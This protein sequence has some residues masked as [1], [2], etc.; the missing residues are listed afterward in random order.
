MV[1][2]LYSSSAE[3]WIV[4]YSADSDV[5]AGFSEE[6]AISDEE[7]QRHLLLLREFR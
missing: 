5:P 6:I 1:D 4:D 7:V 3:I 2:I